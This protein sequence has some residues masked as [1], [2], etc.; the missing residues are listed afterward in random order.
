[1]LNEALKELKTNWDA[2]Y[3]KNKIDFF[4]TFQIGAENGQ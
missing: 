2:K 1:M 3:S 4:G